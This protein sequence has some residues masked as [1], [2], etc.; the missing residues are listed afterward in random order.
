MFK[1]IAPCSTD[2][3]HLFESINIKTKEL[4]HCQARVWSWCARCRWGRGAGTPSTW[5]PRW[6]TGPRTS[7]CCSH[8]PGCSCTPPCC[9][10]RPCC[11]SLDTLYR[12]RCV[13]AAA[14]AAGD[15]RDEG[16]GQRQLLLPPLLRHPGLGHGPHRHRYTQ[17]I[18]GIVLKTSNVSNGF[19]AI[20]VT[21]VF[22]PV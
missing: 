4:H 3:F 16:R 10:G 5:R 22:R 11:R 21:H 7:A 13:D 17:K 8:R 2:S 20:T 14:G 19:A 6:C 12:Y 15:R 18:W 1:R 9:S